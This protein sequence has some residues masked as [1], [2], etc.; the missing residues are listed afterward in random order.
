MFLDRDL[1][2][3]PLLQ[4]LLREHRGKKLQ[5]TVPQRGESRKL[6][7]MAQ[8]NAAQDLPR[9]TMPGAPVLPKA[10]AP[11]RIAMTAF[12]TSHKITTAVRG[13]PKVR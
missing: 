8:N 5:F 9:I 1:P 7:E 12:S 13:P 10:Q 3:L 2:D 4:Q 6:C 11:T